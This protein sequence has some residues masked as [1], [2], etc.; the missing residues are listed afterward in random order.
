MK[1]LPQIVKDS[2]RDI[3][4]F[5]LIGIFLSIGVEYLIR[6]SAIMDVTGAASFIALLQG[7]T[8]FAGANL[9][10]WLLGANVAFPYISRWARSDFNATWRTMEGFRKVQCFLAVAIGELLMAAICFA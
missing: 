9:C 4:A 3:T 8:K 2:W 10:A 7:F 5:L 1:N 6:L